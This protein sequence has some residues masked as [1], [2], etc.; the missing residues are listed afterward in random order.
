MFLTF[1]STLVHFVA[2]RFLMSHVYEFFLVSVLVYI[3]DKNNNHTISEADLYKILI[4]YFFLSITRPSTFLFS[5]LFFGIFKLIIKIKK[6]ALIRLG[7]FAI[8]LS[9]IYVFLARA[10]YGQNSIGLNIGANSTTS[11]YLSDFNFERIFA[12]FLDLFSIFFF[13][14][15]GDCLVNTNSISRYNCSLF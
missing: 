6:I 12:G 5:L 2:T 1:I 13:N 15:Y 3:F 8:L 10:I 14:L 7:I 9:T 4:A 11:G